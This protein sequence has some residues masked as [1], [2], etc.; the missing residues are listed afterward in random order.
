MNPY[1]IIGVDWQVEQSRRET[2]SLE[3]LCRDLE[4]DKAKLVSE[5]G[6]LRAAVLRQRV[7]GA[8]ALQD[9]A[10]EGSKITTAHEEECRGIL[11]DILSDIP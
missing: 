8:G 2:L 7:T 10:L 1:N 11:S 9:G 4:H 5:V 3:H 6:G